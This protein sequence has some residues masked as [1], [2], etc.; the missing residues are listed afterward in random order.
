MGAHRER[1]LDT[2]LQQARR[3]AWSQYGLL[4]AED[5]RAHDLGNR[6][7]RQ[8]LVQRGLLALVH[9]GVWRLCDAR[10]TQRM[11][12]MAACLW[13]GEG[14]LCGPTAL[15]IHRLDGKDEAEAEGL[16]TEDGEDELIHVAISRGGTKAPEGIVVHRLKPMRARAVVIIDGL[17]V[18]SVERTLLDVAGELED[19]RLQW[20]I[21]SAWRRGKL[22]PRRFLRTL[23]ATPS[24]GT[25]GIAVL[26]E[27]LSGA[28][29]RRR[30]LESPLEV[31]AWRAMQR[32]QVPP[33]DVQVELRDDHGNR[34]RADFLF[35]GERLIVEALGYTVHGP[36]DAFESDSDRTTALTAMGYS[37]FPVTWRGLKNI[38]ATLMERLHESLRARR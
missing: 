14:V 29:A 17:R 16:A 10:I 3:K 38:E 11:K 15:R 4:T 22:R 30:P 27:L 5:L 1:V 23:R 18:T 21:E 13:A 31:R 28:L 32:A 2:R 33:P 35:R 6:K 7:A 12:R 36:R 9:P 24:K 19:E 26:K 20:A 25:R 34:F 8:R 37:V